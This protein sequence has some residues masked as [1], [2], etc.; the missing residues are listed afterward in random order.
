M[1][2]FGY[3]WLR[4]K[5]FATSKSWT[6][7]FQVLTFCSKKIINTDYSFLSLREYSPCP[8]F[9][10]CI[11]RLT[12]SVC[13]VY[14]SRR[15]IRSYYAYLCRRMNKEDIELGWTNDELSSIRVEP[16]DTT[17]YSSHI[18][19]SVCGQSPQIWEA[20]PEGGSGTTMPYILFFTFSLFKP[21][22][23]FSKNSRRVF[24]PEKCCPIR[25]LSQM[26]VGFHVIYYKPKVFL[27]LV[28][29]SDFYLSIQNSFPCPKY[30][31][32]F[33]SN[34]P[35][36]FASGTRVNITASTRVYMNNEK[37]MRKHHENNCMVR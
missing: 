10:R 9:T 25:F 27:N 34:A 31:Q 2:A 30:F 37:R 22:A 18:P 36:I 7:L 21:G 4:S 29:F 8:H 14:V 35:L 3:C 28:P 20:A 6:Y 5:W 26:V 33:R 15:P 13:F 17:V 1:Y 24:G 12:I 32:E 23:C 16:N 11:W 19:A